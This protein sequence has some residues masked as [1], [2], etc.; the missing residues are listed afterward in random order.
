MKTYGLSYTFYINILNYDIDIDSYL[1][2][3]YYKYII[4]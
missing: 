2:I 1:C 4:E 3:G